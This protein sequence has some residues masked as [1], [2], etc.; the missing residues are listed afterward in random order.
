MIMTISISARK[1]T[2]RRCTGQ[3][4]TL[5]AGCENDQDKADGEIIGECLSMV[6]WWQLDICLFGICLISLS[7]F[8]IDCVSSTSMKT[9]KTLTTA[10]DLKSSRKPTEH[11]WEPSSSIIFVHYRIQ[12]ERT[13]KYIIHFSAKEGALSMCPWTHLALSEAWEWSRLSRWWEYR[14]YLALCRMRPFTFSCLSSR[15]RPTTQQYLLGSMFEMRAIIQMVVF[16]GRRW[17]PGRR[18]RRR[19]TSRIGAR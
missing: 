4:S 6:C 17:C 13:Y 14:E 3:D 2:H 19:W 7:A 11:R 16:P 8:N 1:E 10:I 18:S 5:A 15:C 12:I 9:S